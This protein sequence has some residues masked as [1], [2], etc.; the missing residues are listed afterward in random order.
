MTTD[1]YFSFF[2]LP[3]AFGLD[4][5]LLK[6]KYYENTR[7]YHPDHFGQENESKQAE[8]LELTTQNNNAYKTLKKFSTRTHYILNLYGLVTEGDKHGLPPAFLGEMMDINEALMELEFEPDTTKIRQTEKEVEILEEQITQQ[9]TS[10]GNS[11]DTT[12]SEKEKTAL[13]QHIKEA[14]HKS[15]YILR[16]KETLHKFAAL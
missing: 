10:L 1:N 6:E 5:K 16:L 4:T 8:M 15:K 2:G 11:F 7:K 9:L 14:Y 12:D 3:I 13:L